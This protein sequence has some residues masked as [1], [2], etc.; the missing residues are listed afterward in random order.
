MGLYE[1]IKSLA[2]QRGISIAQLER[3]LEFSNGSIAKWNDN[4]PSIDKIKKVAKKFDVSTD[5]LLGIENENDSSETYL[6]LNLE[7]LTDDEKELVKED[8]DIFFKA[9]MERIER[10]RKKLGE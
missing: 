7:G 1:N 5:V 10:R 8:M 9:A 4:S 6:R 3:D 2:K